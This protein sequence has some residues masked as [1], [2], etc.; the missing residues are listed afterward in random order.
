VKQPDKKPSKQPPPTPPKPNMKKLNLSVAKE[1][2]K[3][4]NITN[5]AMVPLQPQMPSG[6]EVSNRLSEHPPSP[7][8]R[9]IPPPVPSR[10][11]D[12]LLSNGTGASDR[13]LVT[14]TRKIGKKIPIQLAKGEWSSIYDVRP[15]IKGSRVQVPVISD[16]FIAT[17]SPVQ[18]GLSQLERCVDCL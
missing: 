7:D 13:Q 14:N 2:D 16:C 3:N 9:R 15:R 12:T 18:T 17:C 1:K 10:A 11:P 4:D 5:A 8:P 6:G